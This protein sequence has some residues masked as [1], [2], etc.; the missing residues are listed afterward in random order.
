MRNLRGLATG[1]GSLPHT[2]IREALELI[3]KYVGQ[4]PFWPQLPKLNSLEGMTAQFAEGLPCVELTTEG[5]L[6][7][8]RDR[9]RQLEVF[10][11][12]VIEE[13]LDYFQISERVSCGL[14]EFYRYLQKADL[15]KIVFIKA[16]VTGPFTFAASLKDERDIS[17]LHD[18]V[19][20]QVI[21]KALIMK[22]LWQI[23][24]FKKFG[25]PII[26]FIDEPFLGAFGSAYTPVSR[27]QVVAGLGELAKGIK[28][29]D[30]LV[31]VHCCGN[32]DWGIF[33]DVKDIDII[34]F[35]AFSFMDKFV[36]YAQD[37]DKFL[38]KGGLIC[39][40]IIPTQETGVELTPEI[41][42]LKLQ[43]GINILAKKGV[44][45]GLL[46]ESLL[47]SPACGLGTLKP[48]A[49]R[50]ILHLARELSNLLKS[51]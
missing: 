10:Y 43:E 41:L 7:N 30:V 36:L 35:D 48:E 20:L 22:A 44:D 11:S 18:N 5:L 27:E 32:T 23:K 16:Q 17:L 49:A 25:K 33:T 1:V 51:G 42:L 47:I 13:D 12:K 40:G 37:L 2:D 31:G 34:N 28:S 21:I 9:D 8:S 4:I 46:S 39:W 45:R 3:F 26:I 24:L 15:E 38:K 14:S 19:F 50:K 29:E 6:Y